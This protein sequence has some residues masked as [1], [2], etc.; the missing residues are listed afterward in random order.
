MLKGL[1]VHGNS[2]VLNLGC[3]FVSND[4]F[5]RGGITQVFSG[6]SCL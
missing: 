3:Y 2:D 6:K 1:V 4:V 5:W